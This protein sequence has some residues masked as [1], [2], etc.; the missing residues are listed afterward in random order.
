MSNSVELDKFWS[1]VNKNGAVPEYNPSLGQCW[2][3][4]GTKSKGYGSFRAMGAHRYSYVI[5]RGQIP[6]GLELDHLCRVKH[7]V[8]PSHLEAVTHAENIKRSPMLGTFEKSKTHCAKGHPY[9]KE[10]TRFTKDGR[11]CKACY[12]EFWYAEGGKKDSERKKRIRQLAKKPEK[13]VGTCKLP[14]YCRHGHKLTPDNLYTRPS[15][16]YPEC[17]TCRTTRREVDYERF[18]EARA[19][20]RSAAGEGKHE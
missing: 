4:T 5:A 10:N 7:C 12:K 11:K 20:I 3:W 1:K 13:V 6:R 2:E 18:K 8:N 9:S 19:L 14:G 15:S 17:L 16:K